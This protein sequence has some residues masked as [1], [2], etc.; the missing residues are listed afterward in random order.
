MG[1]LFLGMAIGLAAYT[2]LTDIA[3]RIDQAAL[4]DGLGAVG[5][6]VAPADFVDSA[7]KFDFTGWEQQDRVYWLQLPDG[8]VFGRL[9]IGRIELDTLV[10]KGHSRRVLKRGP[11]WIDYTDLPASSG[12][13]G[14][15]GHRTTYGAPFRRL[16]ELQP[17][18]TIDLYS[19]FRRY[20]YAVSGSQRVT[21][22]RVDV[23][24]AT[25]PEPRLTLSACDPPY[26]ARYRLIVSADLVDVSRI[27][28]D[29]E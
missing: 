3:A 8:E 5:G 9:V 1:N 12:N 29:L 23:M 4:R 24:D 11:G 17:G 6:E 25:T 15:A 10:V 19:P 21:P 27:A 28:G 22:D 18:D 7:E 14:I 26:S 20:R 2:G 16:N 13:V